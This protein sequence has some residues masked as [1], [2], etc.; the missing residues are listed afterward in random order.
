MSKRRKS[1]IISVFIIV[2]SLISVFSYRSF[3][4]LS[5]VLPLITSEELQNKLNMHE[6]IMVYIGRPTCPDC[7]EF[8]PVLRNVLNDASEKIFYYNTDEARK[9]DSKKLDDIAENLSIDAVPTLIKISDGEVIYKKSGKQTKASILEFL[10]FGD[11]GKE[12]E[13]G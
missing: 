1:F 9:I 12:H 4:S 5:D 10:H 11:N 7:H 13:S 3:A 6:D 8:E 2:I